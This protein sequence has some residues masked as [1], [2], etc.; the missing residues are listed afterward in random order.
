MSYVDAEKNKT[1]VKRK[2]DVF[3]ISSKFKIE[4]KKYSLE[5]EYSP[6]EFDKLIKIMV[7]EKL[8]HEEDKLSK[9]L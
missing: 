6:E 5:L 4:D 2:D 3:Y 7:K 1:Y 8:K 9:K